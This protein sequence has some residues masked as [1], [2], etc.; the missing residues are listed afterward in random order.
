MFKRSQHVGPMMDD[1]GQ[2]IGAVCKSVKT[3][4]YG[5]TL[6]WNTLGVSGIQSSKIFITYAFF[7]LSP[8]YMKFWR[9]FKLANLALIFHKIAKLKCTK[10]Y[11]IPP[12]GPFSKI[13]LFYGCL[14]EY[15]SVISASQLKC[16]FF[17]RSNVLQCRHKSFE[18]VKRRTL[19]VS[20]KTDFSKSLN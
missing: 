11:K 1:V 5:P 20:L 12:S 4:Y 13:T 9:H 16:G 3:R 2:E 6:F 15:I 10:I 18:F 19:Q 8:Y 14:R 7:A 17:A